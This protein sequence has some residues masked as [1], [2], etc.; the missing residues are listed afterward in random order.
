MFQTYNSANLAGAV[1]QIAHVSIKCTAFPTTTFKVLF[2][3]WKPALVHAVWQKVQVLLC[4]LHLQVL[5]PQIRRMLRKFTFPILFT[6]LLFGVFYSLAGLGKC[7]S[8]QQESEWK[9]VSWSSSPTASVQHLAGW[10]WVWAEGA[11]QP[12]GPA[13]VGEWQH[14]LGT[15]PWKCD[16][17]VHSSPSCRILGGCRGF[18]A[19]RK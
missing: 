9:L 14:F 13:R 18:G 12:V 2:K 17:P 7:V 11:V 16:S 5:E 1:W 4:L 19:D 10:W 15:L 3:L 8:I 6:F